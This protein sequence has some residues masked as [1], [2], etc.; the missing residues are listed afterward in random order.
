MI[1]YKN[2]F[3]C[4]CPLSHGSK[5]TQIGSSFFMVYSLIGIY[6]HMYIYA[7]IPTYILRT[8]SQGGNH[9]TYV[10]DQV[11]SKLLEVAKKKNKGGMDLKPMHIKNHVWVFVNCLIENPTFDSQT[12]ENMT[13]KAKGF[14]STCALS[15]KFIKLVSA[16]VV[17]LSQRIRKPLRQG[18]TSWT[19][20]VDMEG[21]SECG[22]ITSSVLV[23]FCSMVFL[24]TVSM[25]WPLPD[26]ADLAYD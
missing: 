20:A 21:G 10:V 17:T 22:R 16:F 19:H 24:T 4:L 23:P 1:N 25:L 12:K 9:V 8:P 18:K 14:G 5:H 15:E 26:W 13:L 7:Y 6:I 3:L 2:S 11:T